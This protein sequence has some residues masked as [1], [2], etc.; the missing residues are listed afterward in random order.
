MFYSTLVAAAAFTAAVSAQN[1]S[2]SGTNLTIDPNSV[3]Y[4]VRQAWCRA[5]Q[6]SCPM[7]CGGQA[8]PNTCDPVSNHRPQSSH[9]STN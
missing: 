4:D 8:S 1:Y 6:N 9:I 5:Q 3:D 7:I 2:T